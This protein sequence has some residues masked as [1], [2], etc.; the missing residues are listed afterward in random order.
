MFLDRASSSSGAT[1]GSSNHCRSNTFSWLWVTCGHRSG[2]A[3]VGRARLGVPGAPRPR[4]QGVGSQLTRSPDITDRFS[5]ESRGLLKQVQTP[6]S[7]VPLAQVR[8]GVKSVS[9]PAPRGHRLFLIPESSPYNIVF[10]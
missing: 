10:P 1:S 2:A 6:L 9:T 3:E 5:V 7:Q 4:S 8:Q